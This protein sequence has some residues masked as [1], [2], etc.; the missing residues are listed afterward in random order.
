MHLRWTEAAAADLERIADYLFTWAPER[1]PSLVRSIYDAPETLFSFP[2]RGRPGKEAGTRELVP[3]PRVFAPPLA[4]QDARERA[5]FR[6]DGSGS[7]HVVSMHAHAR[8]P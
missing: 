3:W 2:H 6:H 5:C 7:P 1:A 4:P 8:N